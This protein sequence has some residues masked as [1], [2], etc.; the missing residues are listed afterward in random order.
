MKLP[1][2][3]R[4]VLQL[5]TIVECDRGPFV[6]I[7]KLQTELEQRQA[8]QSPADLFAALRSLRRKQFVAFDSGDAVEVTDTGIAALKAM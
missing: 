3:E 5:L 1:S 8:V 7:E 4:E 6:S 2:A